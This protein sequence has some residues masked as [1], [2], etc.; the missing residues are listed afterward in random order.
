MTASGSGKLLDRRRVE[1]VDEGLP[2]LPHQ[3]KGQGLPLDEAHEFL[4]GAGRGRDGQILAF[5]APG[6]LPICPR[7]AGTD[8][9]LVDVLPACLYCLFDV[10]CKLGHNSRGVFS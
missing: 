4:F 10:C 5:L 2:K 8:G 6:E 9:L 7:Q 1:L 3:S